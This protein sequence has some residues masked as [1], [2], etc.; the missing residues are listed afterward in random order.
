M[1]THPRRGKVPVSVSVSPK[2][3]KVKDF[4]VVE[5][6]DEASALSAS[7]LSKPTTPGLEAKGF[8]S[9]S[10]SGG[11][12]REAVDSPYLYA[13]TDAPSASDTTSSPTLA[14]FQR[15]VPPPPPSTPTPAT[16]P[17]TPTSPTAFRTAS[18]ST[19]TLP[20]TLPSNMSRIDTMQ[21]RTPYT[22]SLLCPVPTFASR[23]APPARQLTTGGNGR[24]EGGVI[25]SDKNS[26]DDDHMV[27][28]DS[29]KEGEDRSFAFGSGF[30]F[31]EV[32]M[33]MKMGMG[34]ATGTGKAVGGDSSTSNGSAGVGSGKG[35]AEASNADCSAGLGLGQGQSLLPSVVLSP[36]R[37]TF[38]PPS[39]TNQR[40][41]NPSPP[42]VPIHPATVPLPHAP[43]FTSP[44]FSALSLNRARPRSESRRSAESGS[45]PSPSPA[46]SPVGY[47]RSSDGSPFPS[48]TKSA[49]ARL[50][51]GTGGFGP[52]GS[53]SPRRVR[54]V[55]ESGGE[56]DKEREDDDGDE[57]D[58]TAA[59]YMIA[60]VHGL[61]VGAVGRPRRG[62][63]AVLSAI[64]VP[65]DSPTLPHFPG[66]SPR[67]AL[68]ESQSK[69]RFSS[70]HIPTP[71]APPKPTIPLPDV[72]SENE[73]EA[74]YGVHRPLPGQV[75]H[76]PTI[77][78]NVPTIFPTD[79]HEH[80][81]SP[82]STNFPSDAGSAAGMEM[83]QDDVKTPNVYI[84]GLPPHF[85][86]DQLFAL[87]A[88]FGEV[89]SVRTFT[90]HVK[91]NESGYG[92]VLW[93]PSFWAL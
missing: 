93:V 27:E 18:L 21:L 56:R 24:G 12:E 49:R 92:F 37:K 50:E 30:G 64:G 28:G 40:T 47:N 62:S 59:M 75:Q 16:A 6:E 35:I 79:K 65:D 36:S 9:I 63:E 44:I 53:G 48:P 10:T 46:S 13:S 67:K 3:I 11:A 26:T 90:R 85:P 20:Y 73:H 69:Q 77:D 34:G 83:A 57:S 25:P 60:A 5:D 7:A 55:E 41:S 42:V 78:T 2:K 87:A 22:P 23:L 89:R 43:A 29:A 54:G 51:S 58:G 15:V 17:H 39:P 70:P 84:N 61:G 33:K 74:L 88:P 86:E 45:P 72:D 14:Q 68:G 91:E 4:V 81:V 32:A 82:T 80:D 52:V 19:A 76:R 66:L 71:S 38:Q 1:E 8:A 31:D